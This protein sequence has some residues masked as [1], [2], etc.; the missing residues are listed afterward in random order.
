M[1]E[2]G[3][4]KKFLTVLCTIFIVAGMLGSGKYTYQSHAL[5]EDEEAWV[6][7]ARLALKEIVADR[8]IMALVYMSDTI[9]VREEPAEESGVAVTVYS[10]H[11]VYIED[12]IINDDYEAWAYVR[13]YSGGT[14]QRGYV[15]RANLAC[16]DERFLAWESDYGMNPGVGVMY[17]GEDGTDGQSSNNGIDQF[18][19]SYQAGLN[20][21]AQ[22]HPNW[23]FVKQV[24]NLDWD[25]VID[26]E[27]L[28][29]RS[30]VYKTFP[31]YTKEGAYDDGNWF[32]ASRGILEYYMDPRNALTESSVFQF[33]QLTYNEEY[34]TLE[35][36]ESFL[37]NT[38]MNS[39]ANAPG[40]KM[41]YAHIIWAI[42]AEDI[43][44]VSPFHLAA[45]IIQEQGVNGGSALI[46]GNYT[47][48][49]GAYKGYYNYFNCGATGTTTQQ[50]IENG[51]AY[52]KGKGWSDAYYSILGGADI[53][54]ANYIRKGQDTLYLQ[55]YNVGPDAQHA[56]YT[57]QYMQNISAPTTEAASMKKLYAN[58]SSLDNT[59]VF[60]I[61]VF[62]NMPEDACP[63]P[64][65]SNGISLAI[66]GGYDTGTVYLDGVAYT[67]EKRNGQ[68]VVTAKDSS[69]KTAVVFS[70]DDN[71]V[72]TG[73]YLW[74]L[75]YKN[76]AYVATKQPKLTDLLTYQGFSVRISEEAGIRCKTGI[77]T[78]LRE[79]LTTDGVA[80]YKL[81]EY[82]TLVMKN[83]NRSTYP[84]IKD[85]QKVLSGMA[86][87][88]DGDG[89]KRD[90][91]AETVNGRYRFTGVLV[92][93]PVEQYKTEFAFGSYAVLKKS[94]KEITVYG[95]VVSKS[96]YSLAEYLL[97]NGAYAE[98]TVPDVFLRKLIAD[99][100]AVSAE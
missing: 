93:L 40:T 53:I 73:M 29:G 28:G 84:M 26:N 90:Y 5:T 23:I 48:A 60:K 63:Y 41:T 46:S 14:E 12:V 38:F 61:P 67:P 98:G 7:E 62:K 42:G 87:G 95:P 68:Y 1:K 66:P 31:D 79:Q 24:T 77:S 72:P 15:S 49:N 43:R 89:K 27:L 47:G 55:K 99:A 88:T 9:D 91:I 65:G 81:T 80:G 94:G 51:L 10:G 45:R 58:A 37:A 92:G 34:H 20:A 35:A 17:S 36:L 71:G 54:S 83:E 96:I 85:G 57:H 8:E 69:A 11:T 25:T 6:A 100:D 13:L 64:T 74:T 76:N 4:M 18:P 21:L 52:A 32:Y 3:F 56:H 33:E 75:Q 39:D 50:V 78:T 44:Q 22:Q 59:F 97:D 86:Y 70:Y 2:R 16:S 82:G 19:E 30:L